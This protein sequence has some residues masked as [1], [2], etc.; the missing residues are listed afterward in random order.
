MNETWKKAQ[1]WES[2]WH[3]NCV[4]SFNEEK[5]Q[6]EYAPLMGLKTTPTHK[7][8][9]TFDLEGKSILDIGGGAYS[10]LLKCENFKEATVCD[11]LMEKYPEWVRQ[12]YD[13]HN[14]DHHNLPGEKLLG[15]DLIYDEVWIYNVLEHVYNPQKVIEN[16]KKLSKI[17]RIYEW[18]DT[19]PNIGH[20]QTLK[21]YELDK[22]L[23]GQGKV[24]NHKRGNAVEKSY[25]GIFK[26][27]HYEEV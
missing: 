12:R 20:P 16:A 1:K 22:W 19:P 10:L 6:L 4:N 5:K 3:G 23:G 13:T 24:T 17:I 25:S 11:P 9:N 15:K 7:T 2:D 8:P 14:I 27:D 21:A 26:G 18:L